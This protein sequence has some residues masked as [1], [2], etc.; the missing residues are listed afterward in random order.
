MACLFEIGLSDEA[1]VL[2]GKI[3]FLKDTNTGEILKDL[4]KDELCFLSSHIKE[5]EDEFHAILKLSQDLAYTNIRS[6]TIEEVIK[7]F[8]DNNPC[9]AHLH[10]DIKCLINASDLYGLRDNKNI[11][12]LFK[13]TYVVD[14]YVALIKPLFSVF[15]VNEENIVNSIISIIGVL[16]R[17]TKDYPI[18]L[19]TTYSQY[20]MVVSATYNLIERVIKEMGSSRKGLLE[21]N[22]VLHADGFKVVV[23]EHNT[24]SIIA[25]GGLIDK[26]DYFTGL[27]LLQKATAL[28]FKLTR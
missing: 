6:G 9:L 23:D 14:D 20:S 28:R 18:Y 16:L 27:T 11:V 22:R 17:Y 7:E 26:H 5:C 4:Y 15:T 8:I 3:V 1:I 2:G 25:P 13:E 12:P 21:I 24:L 10:K 19:D